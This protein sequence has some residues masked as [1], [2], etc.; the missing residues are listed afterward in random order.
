MIR[1]QKPL[2]THYSIK[3]LGSNHLFSSQKAI[4]QLGYKIR[5][6]DETIKD[7]L[8]FAMNYYLIKDGKKWKK[9]LNY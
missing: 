1:G 2:F 7:T 9:K 3:V 5:N 8:D 4:D 6:I